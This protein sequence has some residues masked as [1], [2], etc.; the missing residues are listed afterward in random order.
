[1]RTFFPGN[2]NHILSA[3]VLLGIMIL[4][5][6][7]T[8]SEA[9]LRAVPK[10]YYEGALALGATHEESIFFLVLPAAKSGFLLR[11]Y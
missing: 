4:P 3:S 7:I 8:I 11:L 10:S 1:M 2:G 9:A 6:I 5:T